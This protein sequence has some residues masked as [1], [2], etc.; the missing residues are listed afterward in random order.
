MPMR[1]G[2]RSSLRTEDGAKLTSHVPNLV[3]AAL[4]TT[5]QD[6]RFALLAPFLKQASLVG[7]DYLKKFAAA[8]PGVVILEGELTIKFPNGASIALFGGDNADALRGLY[9]DGLV[10]DETADL[11]PDVWGSIIRPALS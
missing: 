5:K 3:D 6:A 4:R 9:F 10:I 2:L 8:V 1:R 7:W 11:K